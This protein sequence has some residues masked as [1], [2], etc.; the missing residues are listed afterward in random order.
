MAD[1]T[2]PPTTRE[3]GRRRR[4]A[5]ALRM[6]ANASDPSPGLCRALLEIAADELDPAINPEPI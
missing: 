4:L 1:G 3:G 2:V 6:A 5:H